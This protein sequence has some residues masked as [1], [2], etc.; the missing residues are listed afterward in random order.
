MLRLQSAIGIVALLAI[1]WAFGENRR[2]VSLKQAAIGLAATLVTAVVLVKL[3]LVAHAFGAINDAVDTISAASRAGTSFVFGYIGGGPAP[4]DVKAPGADFI[5]AFQALPI[6]LVMS[7]LTT[8]LFYWRV[9]PP[10]VRGMAWL[11]ERTLGVGGAVGLSTAANIFLGMVEAPLFVRPYLAQMTRSELFLVMTGGMAGI[12]GTVLVLY[13]TLL[14]PIIP[15]SA[16]HFVIASVLGAPA[17][18]LIS[19]IMVPET[20]DHLTG[21]ALGDDPKMVASSTMDAIVKGTTAGLELLLNIVAML[22]VLVALVYLANA[23]LGLLPHVGGS[24]ISLQRLLGLVMAPVCWLMGLPWS[25]AVTAGSLMGTKTVLN[26]LIAYVDLS[27]LAPDALD[28]RSRLIMLYAMCGFANF[29]SLGIMIGGLGTTAPERR[30]E[31]NS[32]GL[33]SIVSGTLTTCLMGAIVGVMT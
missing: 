6:V 22:I 7:V 11:L 15:D 30:D 33:K 24:A 29:G 14:A 27:K 31:I 25:Q 21:G 17:A 19:L 10:I 28:P 13:A 20:G 18:I 5:L 26:E 23:I 1:A 12:A 8:L 4:F 3:P 9:L 2:A 16:A 32:L